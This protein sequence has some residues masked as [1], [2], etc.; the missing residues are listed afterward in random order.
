M[1]ATNS[2]MVFEETHI[3]SKEKLASLV[4]KE[5]VE[6]PMDHYEEPGYFFRGAVIGFILCIPFWAAIF[7]LVTR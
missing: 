7:W 4:D 2:A 5:T 6:K 3:T 1:K